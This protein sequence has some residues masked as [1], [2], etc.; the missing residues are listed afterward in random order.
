MNSNVIDDL[1]EDKL[2]GFDDT[3]V[4]LMKE[5]VILL[6][7]NDNPIGS[8][9]KKYAH[10][11]QNIKDNKALHRAFSVLLFNE[12]NELLLQQRSAV[13]KLHFHYVGLIHVVHIH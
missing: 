8:A 5:E 9:T 10:L 12:H 11:W 4:E 13:K 3:Q 7:K 2:K 1:D 6:D